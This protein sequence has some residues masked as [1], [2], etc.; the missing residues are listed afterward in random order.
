MFFFVGRQ[1]AVGRCWVLVGS[2]LSTVRLGGR[3]RL[4]QLTEAWTYPPQVAARPGPARYR[5]PWVNAVSPHFSSWEYYSPRRNQ[6]HGEGTE[7]WSR[8]NCSV[9]TVIQLCLL[10]VL[11][12]TTALGSSPLHSVFTL[13]VISAKQLWQFNNIYAFIGAHQYWHPYGFAWVCKKAF[14]PGHHYACVCEKYHPVRL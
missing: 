12:L 5:R 10:Q 2:T 9:G 14:I 4:K 6:Y 1:E 11:W 13:S 3:P 8:D 7:S